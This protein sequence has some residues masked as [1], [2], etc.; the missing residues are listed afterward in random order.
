MA[1]K[2]LIRDP[3]NTSPFTGL[4][5]RLLKD[6][7]NLLK[8]KDFSTQS[9][10]DMTQLSEIKDIY[11]L[12]KKEAMYVGALY[13]ENWQAAGEE[14]DFDN[15]LEVDVPEMTLYA[16]E[17]YQDVTAW[18]DIYFDVWASDEEFADMGASHDFYYDDETFTEMED[19]GVDYGDYGDVYD[20]EIKIKDDTEDVGD[21]LRENRNI[22][23]NILNEYRRKI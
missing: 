7:F 21:S 4:E 17:Y 19:G 8:G 18:R 10:T 20:S 1:K 22:I 9:D 15:I 3:S 14:G 12:S 16:V 6:L 5:I 11:G 23:K 13:K 2:S